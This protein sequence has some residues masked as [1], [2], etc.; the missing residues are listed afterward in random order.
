MGCDVGRGQHHTLER[1]PCLQV[2]EMKWT[3]C[4]EAAVAQCTGG[5]NGG[6]WWLCA[7]DHL[8]MFKSIWGQE[9]IIPWP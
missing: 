1:R 9:V 7:L 4:S 2:S 6:F 3:V 5:L 8:G